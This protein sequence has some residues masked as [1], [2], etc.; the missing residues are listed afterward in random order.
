LVDVAAA[1]GPQAARLRLASMRSR[2]TRPPSASAR[3]SPSTSSASRL[4]RAG[5]PSHPQHIF[6]SRPHPPVSYTHL[7]LPTIY[8]V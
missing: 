8:S 6:E 7:T 3:R 5:G 1:D 4:R 2:S